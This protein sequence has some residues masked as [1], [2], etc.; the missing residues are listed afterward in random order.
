MYY[1]INILFYI[2]IYIFHYNKNY[3][4]SP[5]RHAI[6][7]AGK[8]SSCI[9]CD[10]GKREQGLQVTLQQSRDRGQDTLTQVQY[11][12]SKY[13]YLTGSPR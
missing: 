10:D 1:V 13:N 5:Y 2:Y 8:L 11:F 6:M 7:D 9:H 12:L 3:M 4:T